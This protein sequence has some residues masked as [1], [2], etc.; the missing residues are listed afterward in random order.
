M[1]STKRKI[2]PNKELDV[3]KL[4]QKSIEECNYMLFSLSDRD[5]LRIKELS[6]WSLESIYQ[7]IYA[8]RIYTKK[9]EADEKTRK[10]ANFG[11]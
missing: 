9:R 7:L 5:P 6:T 10:N 4:V 3:D 8:N 11:K 1:G 2:E